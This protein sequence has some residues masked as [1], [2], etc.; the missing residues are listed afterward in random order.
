[1]TDEQVRVLTYTTS[2]TLPYIR[3]M[4]FYTG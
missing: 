1:M 3:S 2:V 4:F